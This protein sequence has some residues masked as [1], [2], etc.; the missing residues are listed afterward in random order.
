MSTD[1]NTPLFEISDGDDVTYKDDPA[2]IQAKANL[3]AVERVQQEKAEQKWLEREERRVRVEVEKLK[4]EIEEVEKR[5]RELEEAEMRRLA[6]EKDRLEKEVI[7]EKNCAWCIARQTLCLWKPAGHARSCQLCRQ[8]KKPC[9]QFEEMVAEG[10]QRAEGERG[11][12]KR[13]RVAVEEMEV[14]VEE[15]EV[16]AEEM[17]VRAEEMEVWAKETEVRAE[18]MERAERSRK[19]NSGLLLGAEVARAIWQLGDRLSSVMEELAV[20]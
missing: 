8:L 11:S 4:G 14:W 16:R 13:P 12:R 3:V 17:E 6:Q 15:T 1:H 7:P 9:W 20:S 18:E 2:V 19:E 10:K 5:R